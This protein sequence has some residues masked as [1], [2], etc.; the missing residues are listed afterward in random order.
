MQS[1]TD[2][3]KKYTT[4]IDHLGDGTSGSVDLHKNNT[5]GERVAIKTV[6][7]PQGHIDATVIKELHCMQ[8]LYNCPY[9]VK[10]LDVDINNNTMQFMMPYYKYD[11]EHYMHDID[12]T[13]RIM[14]FDTIIDNMLHSL[15]NLYYRGIIHSDIKPGNILI[16]ITGNKPIA[17][18]ADFGL[19]TQ[20]PCDTTDRNVDMGIRGSPIYMAPE[21]LFHNSYFNEKIDIWALGVTMLTY[22]A[23]SEFTY[24]IEYYLMNYPDFDAII[25]ALLSFLTKPLNDTETNYNN[26]KKSL[27]HDHID[28][29]RVL[30][31]FIPK[32]AKLV[33]KGQIDLLSS[34]LQF[35]AEDRLVISSLNEA[36]CPRVKEGLTRGSL[37]D[38]G[39]DDYYKYVNKII[40]VSRA[41]GLQSTTCYAAICLFERYAAHMHVDDIALVA[42]SCI[43]LMAEFYEYEYLTDQSLNTFF[44]STLTMKELTQMQ[45][46]IMKDANYIITYCDMDP[47]I[48]KI[49]EKKFGKLKALYAFEQM[50][51]KL[52]K[53]GIFSGDISSA[54]LAS[55]I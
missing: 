4:Y 22:L 13:K 6:Q 30:E 3:F 24:P 40:Y 39:L 52:K 54:K 12:A 20:L 15:N 26:A 32:E 42:A 53:E 35:N 29:N 16:D 36:I 7:S 48:H 38:M 25:F 46:K 45:L 8:V 49:A 47:V 51:G 31:A 27:I 14:Y 18:L 44:N 9:I 17:Y 10:L 21:M 50:F 2:S 43:M 1:Y 23:D 33:S 11:L 41:N 37:Y 34:M 55:L 28:V 19:S 5:T